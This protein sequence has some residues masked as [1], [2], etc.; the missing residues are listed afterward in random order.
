M[1]NQNK[2][3]ELEQKLK[4]MRPLAFFV[5]GFVL[6]QIFTFTHALILLAVAVLVSPFIE[7]FFS[8]EL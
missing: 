5:L 8:K 3:E 7:N 4:W 6:S 2:N 1:N